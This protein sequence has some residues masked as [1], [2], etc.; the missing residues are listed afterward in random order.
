MMT[1]RSVRRAGLVAMLIICQILAATSPTFA[2]TR[3]EVGYVYLLVGNALRSANREAVDQGRGGRFALEH[4]RG[5]LDSASRWRVWTSISETADSLNNAR[6]HPRLPA[7]GGPFRVPVQLSALYAVWLVALGSVG[8]RYLSHGRRSPM[9]AV[10]KSPR[11]PSS[12]P[13]GYPTT[14]DRKRIVKAVPAGL[15]TLNSNSP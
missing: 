11:D 1:N 15:Q 14:I 8:T 4:D 6:D 2:Q 3:A 9:R 13:M 5:R 10:V 12:S 7:S